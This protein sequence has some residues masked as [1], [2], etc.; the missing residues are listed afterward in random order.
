MLEG[1]LGSLFGKKRGADSDDAAEITGEALLLH[2]TDD[3]FEEK[4]LRSDLP[5]LVDF[6]AEWC[7]PCRMIGPIVAD[8]ARDYEGR[9]LAAKLDTDNN[10]QVSLRYGIRGIPTLIVFKDGQEVERVVGVRSKPALAQMLDR[11]LG[12]N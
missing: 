3:D 6:W 12:D 8:L 9:V 4:V 7:M 10:P 2:V 5:V 11:V 1:L